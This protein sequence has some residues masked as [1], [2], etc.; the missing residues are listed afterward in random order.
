MRIRLFTALL[1]G[2]ALL[3]WQD[4]LVADETPNQLTDQEKAAGWKLLFDG[5]TSEGWHSFKKPLFPAK[6]WTVENGWLHCLGKGGGDLLSQGQY[7]QFELQW[8]WKLAPSGNSGVKYF[9][10]ES[11][12]SAIGHE[13]Q[14]VDDA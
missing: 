5:K 2:I 3:I 6:G 10:L 7:A 13:Y 9:V 14:M 4:L 8:E 12:N 1:H 11:R